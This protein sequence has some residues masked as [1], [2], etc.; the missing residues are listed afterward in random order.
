MREYLKFRLGSYYAAGNQ[1]ANRPRHRKA[2]HLLV[3]EPDSFRPKELRLRKLR[4]SIEAS[5]V[6]VRRNSRWLYP[7]VQTQ[8]SL[9]FVCEIRLMVSTQLS[10]VVV[11]HVSAL[12]TVAM[13]MLWY[14]DGPWISRICTQNHVVVEKRHHASWPTQH[15]VNPRLLLHLLLGQNKCILNLTVSLSEVVVRKPVV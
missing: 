2:W 13:L 11:S 9:S 12:R 14:Q 4:F 10:E 3:F 15:R 1:V 8:D 6:H 7:T 5:C